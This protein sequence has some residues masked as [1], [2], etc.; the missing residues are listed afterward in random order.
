MTNEELKILDSFK[1]AYEDAKYSN[2]SILDF[3]VNR[4]KSP[5]FWEELKK[6]GN[7]TI[8]GMSFGVYFQRKDKEVKK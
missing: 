8:D 4:P 2:I 5:D 7:L 6:L 1:I 3:G